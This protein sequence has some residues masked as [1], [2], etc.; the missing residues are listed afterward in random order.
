MKKSPHRMKHEQRKAIRQA[1]KEEYQT[2]EKEIKDKS[3]KSFIT[4]P[5]T[6]KIA[7]A[8]AS[9]KKKSH[10]TSPSDVTW[11][12]EPENIHQEGRRW[13]KVL[14]KQTLNTAKTLQ[15]KLQKF[16]RKK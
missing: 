3:Q 14:K 6:N 15:K 16:R 7:S 13:I 2:E 4:S 8:K 12:T 10:Q 5:K 11:E 1:Q 9:S